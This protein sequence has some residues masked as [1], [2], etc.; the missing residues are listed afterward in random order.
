MPKTKPITE[1]EFLEQI[2]E[3]A[4]LR[5]WKRAH[6]RPARTAKGWRTAVQGDGK[7]FPDL[8]LLRRG[9]QIVAELKVGRNKTT[10]EQDEWLAAFDAAGA[11][12]FVWY[13]ENWGEILRVLE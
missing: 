4:A 6:F 8:V 12:C 1:A 9:V 13:P 2:L 3:Y 7:G 10:P 11:S 5:G